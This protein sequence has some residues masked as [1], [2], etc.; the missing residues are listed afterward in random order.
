MASRGLS[1][2]LILTLGVFEVLEFLERRSPCLQNRDSCLRREQFPGI[3][4]YVCLC[5]PS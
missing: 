2:P 4:P 1:T 5:F 3:R